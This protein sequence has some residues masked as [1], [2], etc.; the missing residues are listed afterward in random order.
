[1]GM[2]T[3]SAVRIEATAAWQMRSA[4][5]AAIINENS[6]IGINNSK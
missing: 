5:S 1:M 6:G 3:A 2:K 4:N